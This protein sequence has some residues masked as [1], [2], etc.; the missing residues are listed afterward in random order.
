LLQHLNDGLLGSL[1]DF[2]DEIVRPLARN[3]YLIEIELGTVDDGGGTT[4]GFHRGVE[5]G[6]HGGSVR[7]R[8]QRKGAV[9]RQRYRLRCALL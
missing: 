3:T 6:L 1:I 8:R 5:H 9:Q 2:A 4:R 7:I